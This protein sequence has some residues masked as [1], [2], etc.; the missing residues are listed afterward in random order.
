MQATDRLARALLRLLER[1][2]DLDAL[3]AHRVRRNHVPQFGTSGTS[4]TS[5]YDTPP[6]PLE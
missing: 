3:L 1:E 2:R 4:G 6:V 5:G